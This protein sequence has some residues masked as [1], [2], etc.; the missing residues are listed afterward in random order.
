M[1]IY[2]LLVCLGLNLSIYLLHLHLPI[3]WSR[4]IPQQWVPFF[5][6]CNGNPF[7]KFET[8]LVVLTTILS[9]VKFVGVIFYWI[10]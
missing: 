9:Y 1:L 5:L 10:S 3:L 2:H 7:P 4:N 6:F 8:Y